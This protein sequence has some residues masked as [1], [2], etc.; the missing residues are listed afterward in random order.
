MKTFLIVYLIAAVYFYG[1]A[2]ASILK[3]FDKIRP[4]EINPDLAAW[5]PKVHEWVAFFCAVT[6]PIGLAFVYFLL[7]RTISFRPVYWTP[8]GK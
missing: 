3:F 4:T 7:D 1:V 2:K 6:G 8:K 5:Y